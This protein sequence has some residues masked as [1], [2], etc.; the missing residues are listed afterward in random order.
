M[1][2]S[3]V[4]PD[5]I[6]EACV[7]LAADPWGAKVIS[8]GTA[9]VL[10]MRQGLIAPSLLVSLARVPGLAEIEMTPEGLQ[11]GGMVSLTRVAASPEVKDAAPSLATACGLVGNVRVRNVATLGGNLAEA[12]YASDPPSVLASLDALCTV[13]GPA[14]TRSIPVID[15]IT[16]FYSTS[17]Q[18]GEIITGVTIPLLSGATSY[19]KYIS[20]SSEDR[21]CVGV[22]TAAEFDGTEVRALRVV[23]GAVA[24]TPQRFDDI[25]SRAI[26]TGLGPSVIEE[27]AD[28]YANA[29]DPLED[30][31]GSSWYRRRMVKVFVRRGLEAVAPR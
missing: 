7:A 17:L 5:T 12:D 31:R 14:G 28:S 2:V 19:F 4:E 11:V 24:A 9:L 22:A 15:L 26:G 8:G 30:V 29:V 16:G 27:I 21:P 18:A 1:S 3:Y 23:V 13:A 6:D 25:A 20:R 10:M